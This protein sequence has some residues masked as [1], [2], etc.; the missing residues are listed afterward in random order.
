MV[1]LLICSWL[2]QVGLL[3]FIY[4]MDVIFLLFLGNLESQ[5]KIRDRTRLCQLPCLAGRFRK[6]PSL[7]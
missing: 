6:T 7:P 5:N 4:K 3:F 1:L 2:G